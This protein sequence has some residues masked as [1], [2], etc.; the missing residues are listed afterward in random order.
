MMA[1]KTVN[2]RI[3]LKN[4]TEAHWKQAVNFTPLKG[5]LI[6]YS[7]DN[8]SPAFSRLKVGDGSTKVNDLPFID[9]GTINGQE[10]GIVKKEHYADFPFPGSVDKLYIDLSTNKIY[11]YYSPTGT[12]KQLSNFSYTTEKSSLQELLNFDAG[13]LTEGSIINNTLVIQ[14]GQL[15]KLTISETQVITNIKEG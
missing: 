7:P 3:Q 14:N 9:A 10:V 8:G 11:Y 12:Y 6:I 1:S 2:T 4:D 15:P 13:E 5:E